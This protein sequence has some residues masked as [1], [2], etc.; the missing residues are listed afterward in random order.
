MPCSNLDWDGYRKTSV[1]KKRNADDADV[2]DSYGLFFWIQFKESVS[3]SV[4]SALSAFN[5]TIIINKL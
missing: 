3:I 1:D 2:A 4:T 5:S